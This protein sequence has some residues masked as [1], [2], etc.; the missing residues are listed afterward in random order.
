[1]TITELITALETLRA[2]H[3]DV[4]VLTMDGDCYMDDL[5]LNEPEVVAYRCNGDTGNMP[6]VYIGADLF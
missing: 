3:G 2:D 5:F 6:A 4:Q 1:M